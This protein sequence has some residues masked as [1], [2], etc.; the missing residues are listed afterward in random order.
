MQVLKYCFNAYRVLFLCL[1]LCNFALEM[2]FFKTSIYNADRK[3][4]QI[5]NF[6]LIRQYF[7]KMY[8]ANMSKILER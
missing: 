7:T 6:S 8:A 3:Y 5:F 1:V 2:T 4:K